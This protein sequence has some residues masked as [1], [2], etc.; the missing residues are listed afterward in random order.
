VRKNQRRIK[1]SSKVHGISD[2][3]EVGVFAVLGFLR[4]VG[5]L[6]VPRVLGKLYRSLLEVTSN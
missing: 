6:F 1:K 3:S 2:I 5:S 4:V